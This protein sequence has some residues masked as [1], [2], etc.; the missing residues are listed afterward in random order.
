MIEGQLFPGSAA[1]TVGPEPL[2]SGLLDDCASVY[3][4]DHNRV[5]KVSPPAFP[6]VARE[7]AEKADMAR[8]CLGNDLGWAVAKVLRH[9]EENGVSCALFEEL[10]NISDN[11]VKRFIQVRR[12]TPPV[13]TWLR[14]VAALDHGIS[15]QGE[16]CL[17]ALVGCPYEALRA[18]A[19]VA[20]ATVR[21]GTFVPRSR[22][23]HSDFWVGNVMLD[24]AGVRPFVLIDWR[25]SN[26]DGFPIFD[27][28]KF[29]QSSGLGRRALRAEL[30]AHAEALGCDIRDT[31]S[32]L[33]AALGYIWI[34]LE[35]FPPERFLA[36]GENCLATLDNALNG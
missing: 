32:Y 13:L 7:M 3:R 26:V 1:P 4:V 28:V 22:I 33:L 35:Q 2:S 34:H 9:W 10:T 19:E 8:A 11:R 25:G 27:L 5:L 17:Q 20:L 14:A 24:P 16:T 15:D 36:M 6:N 23:M 31:R 30:A 21:S 12:V 18:P 29:A